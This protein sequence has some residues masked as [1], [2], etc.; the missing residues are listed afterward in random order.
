MELEHGQILEFLPIAY[1]SIE[2]LQQIQASL[3]EAE[4][5]MTMVGIFQALLKQ[6]VL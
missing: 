6:M 3:Q 4:D 2:E 1:G 5:I